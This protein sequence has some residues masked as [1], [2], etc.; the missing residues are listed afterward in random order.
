MPRGQNTASL[1]KV[2]SGMNGSEINAVLSA[3]I[4]SFHKG[5]ATYPD[6][7][8]GLETFRKDT[9]AYFTYCKEQ[10]ELA[11]QNNANAVV[12]DIESWAAYLG[13][14]RRTILRYEKSR[15]EEW[16]QAISAAKEIIIACKKQ[17]AFI[18]KM[19]P[20]LA[21]FDLTNN[22]DYVNSN[23]FKL[24]TTAPQEPKQITQEEWEKVIDSE[25]EAP[26]LLFDDY[27]ESSEE[28]PTLS[29]P[30]IGDE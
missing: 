17:L 2:A 6:T 27:E 10:N 16:Q 7:Q 23:E 13:T 11:T 8:I 30:P 15:G 26:K 14:T 5:F 29:Y 28:P 3:G 24:T 1:K 25:P 9:E 22:G 18:G 12:P 20:V 19:P 21:I 4:R